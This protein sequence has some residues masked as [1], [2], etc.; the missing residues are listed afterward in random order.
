MHFKDKVVLITGASSG[1]GKETAILFA[2]HGAKVVLA[3]R[4]EEEGEAVLKE[5]KKAGGEG[6]FVKTD[7]SD[8]KQIEK[9]IDDTLKKY[10]RLDIAFNNAGIEGLPGVFIH[11]QTAK[12]Y[13]TVFNINV[14][15]VLLCMKH[16]VRAMKKSGGGAI[17]NTSSIAGQIGMPGASV[18]V[19]SKHAV[20]GLTKV[21]AV[22]YAQENIRVNAVSPAAIQTDMLDRFFGDNP[23]FKDKVV[24]AH[25]LGRVGQPK[26]VAQAV[27]FL[28]SDEASFI[29]GHCLPVDGGYLVP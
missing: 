15:G 7:V 17:V 6:I 2:E 29:T 16:E 18:Y 20:N 4:R 5:I 27:L 26:E 8:E 28:C 13:D 11:D 9:L 24:Q 1:I 22:E 19:A 10:G 3:A 14:K 21:A 12:E 23:D 25:P